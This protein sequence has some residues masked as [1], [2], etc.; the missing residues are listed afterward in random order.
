MNAIKITVAE[1]RA[2]T[3]GARKI[4][5]DMR[6]GER[7]VFP[8][9][10]TDGSTHRIDAEVLCESMDPRTYSTPWSRYSGL[11]ETA[12][13]LGGSFAVLDLHG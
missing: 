2:K 13:M 9:V 3:E 6:L 12:K 7:V 1:Q 11:S 5:A 8:G 4:L 10:V